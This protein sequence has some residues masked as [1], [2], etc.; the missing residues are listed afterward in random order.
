VF[1]R[2]STR[3]GKGVR[4]SL[5]GIRSSEARNWSSE[6]NGIRETRRSFKRN[7]I[8][9]AALPFSIQIPSLEE[10]QK[11]SQN[12][13]A[14]K[15]SRRDQIKNL[16]N[17]LEEN[18]VLKETI[19]T[20]KSSQIESDSN[21]QKGKE[22]VEEHESEIKLLKEK[23]IRLTDLNLLKARKEKLEEIQNLAKDNEDLRKS[24]KSLKLNLKKFGGKK[25]TVLEFQEKT[26]Q[27]RKLDEKLETLLNENSKLQQTLIDSKK[28][29]SSSA[30][31]SSIC[32]DLKLILSDIL[33]I[34]YVA[35]ALLKKES[36]DFSKLISN[37][38]CL[39]LESVPEYLDKTRK[40]LEGLRRKSTDLY[41]EHC[42]SSCNTQ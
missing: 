30:N 16:R 3:E 7:S 12:F 18:R 11:I 32:L 27:K 9:V 8:D 28:K 14:P 26:K 29:N 13:S 22:L 20:F 15:S 5:G 34:S 41:A 24:I 10:I 40:T 25:T 35:G 37:D 19:N 17:K 31:P 33:K 38:F 36:L 1:C 21:L 39:E 23:L 2:I 4:E 6:N 42:G